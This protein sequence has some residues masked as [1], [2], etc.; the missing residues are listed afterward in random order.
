MSEPS[1]PNLAPDETADRIRA[2]LHEHFPLS[3]HEIKTDD[4]PLLDSG[5]VDSLGI[6]EIV[7]YLVEAFQIEVSDD[8]LNAETFGSIT[9]LAS[10]VR[11]KSPDRE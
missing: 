9:A 8:D 2:Y 4:D 10:F 11:Q 7:D 3:R 5:V 1:G 6:L